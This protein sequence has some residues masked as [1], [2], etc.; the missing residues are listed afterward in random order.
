MPYKIILCLLSVMALT[1][2]TAS[3][4]SSSTDELR[5]IFTRHGEKVQGDSLWTVA[6]QAQRQT[7]QSSDGWATHQIIQSGACNSQDV[8]SAINEI[9]KIADS[10]TIDWCDEPLCIF[11]TA[12]RDTTKV[13]DFAMSDAQFAKFMHRSPKLAGLLDES[14]SIPKS[15]WFRWYRQPRAG[16]DVAPLLSR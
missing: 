7:R 15:Y 12:H 3:R 4:P 9:A 13:L 11:I 10:D 6:A 16:D 5:V 8:L 14:L 1:A 2:C